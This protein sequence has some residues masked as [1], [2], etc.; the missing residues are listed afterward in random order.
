MSYVQGVNLL[1]ATGEWVYDSIPY[2]ALRSGASTYVQQNLNFN[3]GG[4]ETDCDVS[5]DRLQAQYPGCGTVALVVAW[6]G[7]STDASACQVFPSTTFIGGSFQKY[8][9][10]TW[11][12]DDWQ[13]SSLT[14]NSTGLI[15]IP[16][17]GGSAVYGGTPSDQ[18]V[19]RCIED[20]KARGFR[21][22]FYPLILMT[23][24]GLPWRGRI[25]YPAD[26]SSAATAAVSAFLGTATASQFMRDPVHLTVTYSGSAT[27]YSFRRMIQHY[28]NLCVVA[29]G[30]DN[31][32]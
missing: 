18:S 28:A 8:T 23:S 31:F 1:P 15:P 17:I 10:G 7:D 9:G 5:L 14:Q 19:V 25:A 4:A 20:L 12:A 22:V 16:T 3:P 26:V 13:V 27:D 30:V 32:I 24:S 6:F 11:V 29:G 2:R 21:V